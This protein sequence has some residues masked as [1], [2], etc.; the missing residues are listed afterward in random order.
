MGKSLR[1]LPP[2]P[3]KPIAPVWLSPAA[4]AVWNELAPFMHRAGLLYPAEALL[5]GTY[6]EGTA[7][8]RGLIVY[9]REHGSYTKAGLATSRQRIAPWVRR[10]E[11]IEKM[12][13]NL[14][15]A[16]LMTPRARARHGITIPAGLENG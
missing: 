2:S 10:C 6:C 9:T 4:L 14:E 5:F 12:L 1:I 3:E 8:Y 16:F 11:R 13:A 7:E 15:A